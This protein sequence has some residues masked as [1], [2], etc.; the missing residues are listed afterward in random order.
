MSRYH[1]DDGTFASGLFTAIV[2]AASFICGYALRDSG[3]IIRVNQPPPQ[4]VRTQ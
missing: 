1:K 4:E 2:V 3:F